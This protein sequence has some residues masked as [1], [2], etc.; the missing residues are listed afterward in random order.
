MVHYFLPPIIFRKLF[1]HSAVSNLVIADT[2]L[3]EI[4]IKNLGSSFIPNLPLP[5]GRRR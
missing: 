2:N 5:A 1:T 4:N 3:H